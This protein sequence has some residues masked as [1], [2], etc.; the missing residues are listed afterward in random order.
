MSQGHRCIRIL[1]RQK[2]GRHTRPTTRAA[3]E[4]ALER[5][6]IAGLDICP[7]VAADSDWLPG[8]CLCV[9][10]PGATAR[11]TGFECDPNP[12]DPAV[13]LFFYQQKELSDGTIES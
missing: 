3:L 2:D 7:N 13:D 12:S 9:L 10:D 1:V 11:N 4:A 6:A 5:K 8:D